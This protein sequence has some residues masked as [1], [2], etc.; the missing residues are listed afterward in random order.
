MSSHVQ[1]G[2]DEEGEEVGA[3]EKSGA[4]LPTTMARQFFF[5]SSSAGASIGGGFV[6]GV[7]LG[8]ELDEQH[9]VALVDEGGRAVLRDGLPAS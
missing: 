3:D 5:A 1:A 4:S 7:H 8:V 9:A 2:A 6:D